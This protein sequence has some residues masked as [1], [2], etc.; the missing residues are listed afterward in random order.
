MVGYLMRSGSAVLLQADMGG[1]QQRY[2]IRR[3]DPQETPVPNMQVVD[4][5]KTYLFIADDCIL[6]LVS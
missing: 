3:D 6:S 4:S 5:L 2:A 1:T